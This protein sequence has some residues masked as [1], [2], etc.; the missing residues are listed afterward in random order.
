MGYWTELLMAYAVAVTA[1]AATILATWN[2]GR[3]RGDERTESPPR[4]VVSEGGKQEQR[5]AA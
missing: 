4:L 1:I 5:P 3:Q 2:A